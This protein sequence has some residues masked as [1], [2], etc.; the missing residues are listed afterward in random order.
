[1]KQIEDKTLEGARKKFIFSMVLLGLAIVYLISPIDIIP[2]VIFPAGY[3][4]DIPLL[5]TTALYAGYTYRK[6]KKSQDREK[7]NV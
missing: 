2:D 7:E 5:L 4:E 1:M 3:L 6:M